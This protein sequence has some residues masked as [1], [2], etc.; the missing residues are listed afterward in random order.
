MKS[1]VF[2]IGLVFLTNIFTSCKKDEKGGTPL[3]LPPQGSLVMDFKDFSQ[4]GTDKSTN[5]EHDNKNWAVLNTSVW[6]FILASTLVIPVESFKEAFKHDPTEQPD[7]SWLWKYDITHS[8]NTY[9]AQLNGKLSGGNVKWEM[10]IT[11]LG[12]YSEFLWFEGTSKADNT[13]GSWTLY[14]NPFDPVMFLDIV[15]HKT[16]E[17]NADIKYTNVIP[18][19]SANGSYI[20]YGITT[21]QPYNAYYD[22][23]DIVNGNLL[24]INWNT[25]TKEGRVK[26][27]IYFGDSNFHYWNSDGNDSIQ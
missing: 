20:H 3:S 13:E 1:L 15:W 24:D 23:Y 4:G 12:N 8:N 21:N 17:S 6:N 10:R 16:S 11:K 26:D 27:S 14:K 19:D 22:I 18:N 2:L 7:G 5:S 25:I 9:N